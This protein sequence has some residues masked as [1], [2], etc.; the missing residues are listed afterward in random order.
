MEPAEVAFPRTVRV[1]LVDRSALAPLESEWRALADA[2]LEPNVFQEAFFLEPSLKAL[3]SGDPL[4]IVSIRSDDTLIGLFTLV[5]TPRYRGLPFTAL[6]LWRHPYEAL[7]TPLVHRDYAG[8]CLDAF[9]DWLATRPEHFVEL[10]DVSADSPFR[11]A[12]VDT[13]R[14]RRATFFSI[15]A[16]TRAIFRPDKDAET[17]LSKA[18]T[19]KARKEFRRLERRL[20]E[21]GTL[22]YRAL[23]TEADA[24]AFVDGF[25]ALEA[26]G[27]K[28]QAGTA[29]ASSPA[30][31]E[32]FRSVVTGAAR[33][34]KF[35]GLVLSVGEKPI[36]MRCA[37]RSGGTSFAW[38]I[39]YDEAHAKASP[40]VLLELENI[41]RMHESGVSLMDSCAV[42]EHFMA[43][44]LWQGKRLIDTVI[45]PAGGAGSTWLVAAMPLLQ[46]TRRSARGLIDRARK[47]DAKRE[48]R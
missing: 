16:H 24:N 13:L 36:A 10:S 23:S 40:G 12:L 43:N 11:W 22:A 3:A 31:R 47:S 25:L 28:G 1:S 15:E 26:G 33:I 18:L 5:R 6:S 8:E 34:G 46:W 41:R 30:H 7:G 9:L 21:Q 20:G 29:F 27:W 37:L 45:L 32:F 39:A 42:P 38:K 14:R 48:N 19:G 35:D 17:Y 2:A 4:Q 44:R